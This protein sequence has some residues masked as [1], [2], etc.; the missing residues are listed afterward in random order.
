MYIAILDTGAYQ[1][2][3]ASHHCLLSSP[4]KLIAAPIRSVLVLLPWPILLLIAG[5][6]LDLVSEKR[7]IEIFRYGLYAV[8]TLLFWLVFWASATWVVNDTP[9]FVSFDDLSVVIISAVLMGF[10]SINLLRI[11]KR[12]VLLNLK[13]ENKEV[14]GSAGN[15]V[16]KIIGLDPAEGMLVIKSP[17]GQKM[18]VHLEDVERVGEKVLLAV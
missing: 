18:T 10:A 2:S 8:F 17:L 9:P 16:G 12:K 1:D 15:Y 3:L 4:A 11:M 14:L 5:R 6:V 7:K 13:L